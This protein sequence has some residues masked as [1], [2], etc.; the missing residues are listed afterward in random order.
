MR[1]DRDAA[2]GLNEFLIVRTIEHCREI[3]V[4]ALSL[5]FAFLRGIIRPQGPQRPMERLQRWLASRLGPWFQIES[6]YRF[7][8]KFAPIW[9]PRYAAYEGPMSM[10]AVVLAALRA[11]KLLDLGTVRRRSAR[12]KPETAAAAQA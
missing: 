11:E 9:R 6:L 3:G 7:N 2:P 8:S 4:S 1:R 12:R 10:P 5:N